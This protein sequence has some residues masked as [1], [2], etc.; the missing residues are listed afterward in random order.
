MANRLPIL[1]VDDDEISRQITAKILNQAGY[2]VAQ[3]ASGE[4]ALEMFRHQKF[5]L[6]YT[7]LVMNQMSGTQLCAEIKKLSPETPVVLISAYP[8]A[9][10]K[11]LPQFMEAGGSDMLKKPFLPEILLNMTRDLLKD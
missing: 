10:A 7:D 8:I 1:V 4:D 11:K 5:G 9:V 3:A 2:E 6:V